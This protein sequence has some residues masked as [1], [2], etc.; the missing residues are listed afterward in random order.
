M[1]NLWALVGHFI[2]YVSAQLLLCINA[3]AQSV[4]VP[5]NVVDAQLT[6]LA[7]VMWVP[8]TVVSDNNA[9]L[10]F[11]VAGRLI[12]LKRIGSSVAKG[13]VIARID[14]Q[15][16]RLKRDELSAMANS[17]RHQLSYLNTQR[18]RQTQLSQRH[19]VAQATI[20]KIN[21]QY[22]IAAGDLGQAR[23]R[24]AQVNRELTLTSLRAPFDGV[25]T[26]KLAQIG[27]YVDEQSPIARFVQT[28]DLEV[29]AQVPAKLKAFIDKNSVFSVVSHFGEHSPVRLKTLVPVADDRSRQ[30]ELRL[31]IHSLSWPVGLD[32][33]VAVPIHEKKQAVVVPRDALVIRREGT[34]VFRILQNNIAQRLSV[35]IGLSDGSLI[36]VIGD[37]KP[38]HRIV[39]R[40]AE[41]LSTGQPVIIKHNSDSLV[42]R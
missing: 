2:C 21:A 20:D 36:E 29:K 8:G 3:T 14:D 5:V 25:I 27:E 7:P 41:R 35:D 4:P 32:V 34:S 28:R 30:M 11:E 1:S 17:A 42:I 33:D 40:G 37:V 15:R 22:E 31:D 10:S 19:L 6:V 13:E 23:A 24:L 9:L 18:Q 26:Q 38:G 39:I 12:E 16:L